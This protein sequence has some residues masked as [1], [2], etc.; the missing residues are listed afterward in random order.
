MT[1]EEILQ[2]LKEGANFEMKYKDIGWV[3]WGAI[4]NFPQCKL[5]RMTPNE[6]SKHY[7]EKAALLESLPWTK[8]VQNP[9]APE[10]DEY[11]TEDGEYLTML[12][13]DEHKILCNTF[14]DGRWLLYDRT[15]V[16][17]WMPLPLKNI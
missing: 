16:K 11:P 15:H 14:R 17:W 1:S 10:A 4:N 9:R 3:G 7:D 13:C 12:D 6:Y 8:E 2:A 5:G